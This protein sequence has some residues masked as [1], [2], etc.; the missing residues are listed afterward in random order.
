[1]NKL[2]KLLQYLNKLTN[3]WKKPIYRMKIL[4]CNNSKV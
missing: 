3:Q 4:L 1:M 2:R